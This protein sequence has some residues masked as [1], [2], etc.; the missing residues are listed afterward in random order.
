MGVMLFSTQT[1]SSNY[2]NACKQQ[3]QFCQNSLNTME[4]DATQSRNVYIVPHPSFV[5]KDSFSNTMGFNEFHDT[6]QNYKRKTV[7]AINFSDFER[8][9]KIPRIDFTNNVMDINA[10]LNETTAGLRYTTKK[11]ERAARGAFT[12]SE[13]FDAI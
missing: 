13:Y 5:R 3:T 7:E 6:Q 8:I 12:V 11:D 1:P 4:T 10:N 9:D 2:N